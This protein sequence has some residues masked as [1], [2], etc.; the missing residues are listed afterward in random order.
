MREPFSRLPPR[1]SPLGSEQ[2][3]A[4]DRE[5]ILWAVDR[6]SAN[7]RARLGESLASIQ[8]YDAPVEQA[9]TASLEALRSHSLGIKTRL[10]EGDKGAVPFF[11]RATELDPKF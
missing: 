8:K 5:R 10:T 7:L 11:A 6:A 4:D 1:H 9:T 2:V 3:E